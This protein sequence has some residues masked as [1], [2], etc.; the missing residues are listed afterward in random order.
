VE[1][2]NPARTETNEE[3]RRLD[4]RLREVWSKHPNFFFVPHST[5]FFAKLQ[6]GLSRLQTIVDENGLLHRGS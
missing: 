5:S 3:A 4:I 2:G 1:G 6:N